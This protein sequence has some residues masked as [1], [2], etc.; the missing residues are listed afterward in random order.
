MSPTN[1]F[2]VS[3]GSILS[4]LKAGS[5]LTLASPLTNLTYAVVVDVPTAGVVANVTAKT[6][7]GF[8]VT[9]SAPVTG[10]AF[11]TVLRQM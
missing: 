8:T 5:T 10:T 3:A 7:S 2:T 6:T 1:T 11:Y 9:F 4:N